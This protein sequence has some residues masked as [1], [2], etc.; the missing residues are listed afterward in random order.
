MQLLNK[1]RGL[2]LTVYGKDLMGLLNGRNEY[3][4]VSTMDSFCDILKEKYILE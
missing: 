4:R 2:I 1:Q 3:G